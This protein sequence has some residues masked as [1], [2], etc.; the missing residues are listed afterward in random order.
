M[1]AMRP[2]N[3]AMNHQFVSLNVVCFIVVCDI[4]TRLGKY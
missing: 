4:N 3:V 1:A 2:K